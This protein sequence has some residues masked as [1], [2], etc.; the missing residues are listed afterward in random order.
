MR[1]VTRLPSYRTDH[2]ARTVLTYPPTVIGGVLSCMSTNTFRTPKFVDHIIEGDDGLVVGTVR[3]K[4]SGIGWAPADGKKWRLVSLDK[5]VK[6]MEEH[7][8]L[9]EK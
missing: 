4:P 5:F 7:G 9:V 8:R 2:A 3:V 1:G 6:F